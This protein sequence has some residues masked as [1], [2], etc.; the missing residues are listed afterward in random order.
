MGYEC[1]LLRMLLEN[2]YCNDSIKL[3]FLNPH[4]CNGNGAW[5]AFGMYNQNRQGLY[6]KCNRLDTAYGFTAWRSHE[7]FEMKPRPSKSV[8]LLLSFY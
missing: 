4:L 1:G 6:G 5:H 7:P 3:P 8:R 2:A